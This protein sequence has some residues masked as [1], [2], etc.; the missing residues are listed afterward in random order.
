MAVSVPDNIAAFFETPTPEAWLDEACERLPELLLD[1]ANC[2]LKAASP[3]R[4]C[5]TSSRCAQSWTIWTFRS[6]A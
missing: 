1:H 3:A 4:S 6:N 2:E 5:G